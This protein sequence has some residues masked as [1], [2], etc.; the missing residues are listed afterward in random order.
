LAEITRLLVETGAKWLSIVAHGEPGVIHLGKRPIDLQ[1]IQNQSQ[2]LQEWGVGSIALY[3]C[4]VAQGNVGKNL[5]YQL[6]ELTGATVAASDTKTGCTTLDG[7]N[8]SSGNYLSPTPVN[9][10]RLMVKR[11]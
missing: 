7:T 6:S 9:T 8:I 5:I 1:Q 2:L 3:S 11:G 10:V 4:E